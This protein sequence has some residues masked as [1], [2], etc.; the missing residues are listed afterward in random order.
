MWNKGLRRIVKRVWEFFVVNIVPCSVLYR[1][2]IINPTRRNR[3][4]IGEMCSKYMCTHINF[5]HESA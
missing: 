4:R 2:S 3:S 1:I 5:I